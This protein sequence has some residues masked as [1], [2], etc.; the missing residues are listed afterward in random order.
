MRAFQCEDLKTF[1]RELFT[2]ER[3]DSFL[4]RE[5][6][7]VTFCRFSVDGKSERD[8]YTEEELEEERVEDYTSWGKL[9]P[10]C[11]Q[12]IRGSRT[13]LKFQLSFRLP[14]AE[15]E[16]LAE[17]CGITGTA[18]ETAGFYVNIRFEEGKLRCFTAAALSQFF[19]D[20]RAERAWDDRVW[21]W[22]QRAGLSMREETGD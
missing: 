13:P 11:F 7:F 6:S 4:V 17:S 2:R 14:P 21:E 1:T 3:F 12:L 22:F 15:S 20:K 9:R 18:A 16:R 8:W 10:V 5:A 19:P